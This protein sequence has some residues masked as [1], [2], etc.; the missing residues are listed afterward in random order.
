MGHRHKLELKVGLDTRYRFKRAVDCDI[1]ELESVLDYFAPRD[2]QKGNWQHNP[3]PPDSEEAY[4]SCY[5]TIRKIYPDCQL[6]VAQY[7]R[8]ALADK[9]EGSSA[10]LE[11][12][13]TL[14]KYLT[15]SETEE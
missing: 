9:K 8:R 6:T 7:M 15:E 4:R 2:E 11:L 3:I 13:K 10:I 12:T 1:V 14:A 5:E